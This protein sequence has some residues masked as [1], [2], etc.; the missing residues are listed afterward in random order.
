MSIHAPCAH[1][2]TVAPDLETIFVLDSHLQMADGFVRCTECETH[3]LLEMVDLTSKAVLYRV[4]RLNAETVAKT[5]RSLNK[6]SCDLDRARNEV[7]TLSNGACPLD[8]LLLYAD[9]GYTGLVPNPRPD[10]PAIGWRELPCDGALIAAL[11]KDS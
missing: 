5:V 7:F 10:L 2:R 9:G 11:E 8:A 3:Y 6:G 4:S 1:L